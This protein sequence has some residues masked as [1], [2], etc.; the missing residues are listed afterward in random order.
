MAKNR[1]EVIPGIVALVFLYIPA[2]AVAASVVEGRV[3]RKA[4]FSPLAG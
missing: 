1:P 2:P 4:T 3:G